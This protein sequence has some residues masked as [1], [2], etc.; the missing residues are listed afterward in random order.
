[1]NDAARPG[2]AALDRLHR[3]ARP[4]AWPLGWAGLWEAEIDVVQWL[5]GAV[6]EV[7]SA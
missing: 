4:P 2:R 1:V 6:Q 7:L 3:H 5:A